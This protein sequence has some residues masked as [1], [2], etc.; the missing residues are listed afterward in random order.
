V[1]TIFTIDTG[2][3]EHGIGYFKKWLEIY[4]DTIKNGFI[5]VTEAKNLKDS[6]FFN[7][8]GALNSYKWDELWLVN[9]Y[10]SY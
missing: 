5:G 10:D 1:Y 4:S 8:K 9:R 6:K 2:A 7:G 3:D